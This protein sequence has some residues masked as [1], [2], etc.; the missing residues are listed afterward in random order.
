MTVENIVSIGDT[1]FGQL[2]TLMN[3]Y[4][5]GSAVH[6]FGKRSGTMSNGQPFGPYHQRHQFKS[7]VAYA[8]SAVRDDVL[9]HSDTDINSMDMRS[10]SF[11]GVGLNAKTKEYIQQRG[12]H[13]MAA[14]YIPM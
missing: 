10:F 11:E 6:V 8:T 4:L 2:R 3:T 5:S 12:S 14:H 13:Y 7:P 1:W 9:N